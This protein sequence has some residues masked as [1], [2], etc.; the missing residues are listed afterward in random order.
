MILVKKLLRGA[1]IDISS[2]GNPNLDF[3]YTM[4][5]ISGTT[6]FDDSPNGNDA[7][8]TGAIAVSGKIGNALSFDG[9]DF[10]VSTVTPPPGS[11]SVA[12]WF[13]ADNVISNERL[14]D[15]GRGTGGLGSKSGWHTKYTDG[16]YCLVDDGAGQFIQFSGIDPEGE[17][18]WSSGTYHFVVAQYD[19]TAKTLEYYLNA[20]LFRT[21]TNGS[22][23]T[24][25]PSD[26]LTLATDATSRTLQFFTG[27]L[28]SVRLFTRILSQEEIDSLFNGGA[29]V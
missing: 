7:T 3:I 23:G 17:P 4:D 1:D 24:V 11:F 25:T 12:F 21:E 8:I 16:D 20:T 27:D 9:N 15:G 5:N 13:N 10:V 2:P 14:V 29:G 28:D 26:A 19:A 18:P 22:M 6:L